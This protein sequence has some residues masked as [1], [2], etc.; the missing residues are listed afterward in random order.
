MEFVTIRLGGTD[1]VF[2]ENNRVRV[3]FALP[4][5]AAVVYPLLQSFR[6]INHDDDKHL[7]DVQVRLTPLFNAGA[8]T[9]QGELEIETTFRDDEGVFP[10]G[11]LV[12]MEVVV[13]VV[14]V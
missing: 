13:L 10:G 6:F 4:A 2:A 11:D 1:R 9:T 7:R 3:P 5:P 12:E 8:S 14:G